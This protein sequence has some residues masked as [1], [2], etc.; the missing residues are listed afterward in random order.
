MSA[1]D[2]AAEPY[3]A[4][5]LDGV[6]LIEASAGTGKTYTLATLFT[7]L[8]VEQRLRM[9]Q[10]LAVTYTEAAT[11]ELRKRIRERLA[12]AADVIGM[13]VRDDEDHEIALTRFILDRHL[14]G[15][16]ETPAQLARRLRT[17]VEETD[18][19]AIFTIHGF[20]ARVLR[21]HAL[22]AGQGLAAVELLGNA[23]DLYAEVAADLWRVHA[24]DPET[25][26]ALIGLWKDPDTLAED[27]PALCKPLPLYPAAPAAG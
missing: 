6:Q 22:E 19:A 20:C 15:G 2:L 10:V 21:E 3:L 26:D 17:A 27:L 13:P 25:A 12:L 5:A 8:I 4:R 1:P 24:A 14:A 7:R 23:R 11:Q 18:L 9:G 16:T